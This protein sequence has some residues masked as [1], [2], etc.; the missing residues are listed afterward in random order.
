[1]TPTEQQ[2][3][4][5][6]GFWHEVERGEAA[7]ARVVRAALRNDEL[8]H[9]WLV[10]GLPGVGQAE[11]TRALAASLNCPNAAAPDQPCQR[12]DCSVCVRVGRDT[13]PAVQVFQPEGQFH[14]VDS[15]RDE[16]MQAATRSMTEGHR[17]VLRIVAADRMNEAAQNAFLK[18]LEEPPASVVWILEATDDAML[19]ETIV[20][21]CRRLDLVP[22]TPQ[23]LA[24]RAAALDV[25]EERREVLARAAMGSPARLAELAQDDVADA[26]LRHLGLVA[27]LAEE[28]PGR[29]VPLA[30]ELSDWAKSRVEP[31]QERQE[32][33][34][35]RLR[36]DFGAEDNDRAWPAGMKNRIKRRHKRLQ[37]QEQRRALDMLLDDLASYLR[38]LLAVASGGDATMLIN[39]D[40]TAALER[41]AQRLPPTA[42]IEGL[43]AI[44]RCR[45]ALDRNGQPELQLERLLMAIALPLYHAAASA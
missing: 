8:G 17:K 19:L 10:T 24:E 6:L 1:M 23:A 31:L 27:R 45:E 36:A 43:V 20:S 40:Q 11:L 3:G 14:T 32:E 35:E 29:I 18:I 30:K 4:R 26:R 41:D 21:R 37:R 25:P 22:W 34:F 38:D 15:V 13:Y 5:D 39:L 2:D 42:C 28:G 9:A 7:A 16:W 12:E 33:E 44:E